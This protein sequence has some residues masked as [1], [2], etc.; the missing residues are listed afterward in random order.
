MTRNHQTALIPWSA[1]LLRRD[2]NARAQHLATTS[3]L[4]HE[5]T[6]GSEPSILFGHE[7]QAEQSRHGNFH[8][9]SYAAICANPAWS[10][11]LTKAHTAH[12]RV[13]ARADWQ[14][15]ELD[16]ANSSDALLMNIFCHPG[17]FSNGRLNPTVANLLGVPS[18]TQPNFGIHPGVPLKKSP[19]TRKKKRAPSTNKISHRHSSATPAYSQI[20][21]NRTNHFTSKTAPRSTSN[22]AH[23]SSKP[24]SP[25]PTSRPQVHASSD[26]TVISKPSLP[27][28]ASPS[29]SSHHQ[30][31]HWQRTSPTSKS[32]PPSNAT[33]FKS[34]AFPHNHPGLPTHPQ[35]PRRLRLRRILLRPLRRAPPRPHRDLVLNPIRRPL[36][37]LRLAPEAPNLAGTDIHPPRRPATIPR[38]KV[39]NPPHRI[40][41]LALV[42][43]PDLHA[44]LF[45]SI[46]CNVFENR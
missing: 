15:M 36:P 46:T 31:T 9:A 45:P 17:V 38:S 12:R 22:S 40:S 8:P 29:K 10:R 25:N 37:Q 6:T 20:H 32:S 30:R 35:R 24:S 19:A 42:S 5:Q 23:S 18:D 1:S 2:L 28:S 43:W 44:F 34:D 21:H 7:E 3:N 16:S 11:R 26:A 33:K 14:W 4:L 39:R 13:R 27:S 41:C